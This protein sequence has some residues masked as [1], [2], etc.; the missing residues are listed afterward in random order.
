MC[1]ESSDSSDKSSDFDKTICD[2]DSKSTQATNISDETPKS[3]Q[4][5][6]I[7]D[8]TPKS[9]QVTIT[10]DETPKSTQVT[11]T[12]DE[13]PK[14]TQ[15]TNISDETPKSTQATIHELVKSS[16]VSDKLLTF[17]VE[18]LLINIQK[19]EDEQEKPIP[20]RTS[21]LTIKECVDILR[22]EGAFDFWVLDLGV[23]SGLKYA[24]Y[25]VTCTGT[26]TRHLRAVTGRLAKEVGHRE[27]NTH[28][29]F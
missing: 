21:P 1:R 11:I 29:Q 22:D 18:D 19:E 5:T 6:N 24:R 17:D 28:S 26:S 15:A 10:S 27:Q 16:K 7:S 9:T 4:A 2:G 20:E 13:T 8:E 14:S 25:F 12:S 3:T 23:A